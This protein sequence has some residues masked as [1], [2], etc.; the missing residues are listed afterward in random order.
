M[1]RWHLVLAIGLSVRA[2]SAQPV[3]A[4]VGPLQPPER[5]QGP[6][7]SNE[8]AK[9]RHSF[10][11][12]W[13]LRLEV[14]P[15]Y[16]LIYDL[17]IVGGEL[18]VGAEKRFPGWIIFIGGSFT[19]GAR[20]TGLPVYQ[21]HPIVVSFEAVLGPVRLG[22]GARLGEIV[23]PTVTSDSAA[24]DPMIGL[25]AGASVDVARFDKGNRALYVA[26]RVYLD[27]VDSFML[28]GG[29]EAAAI[30]GPSF[31]VGARL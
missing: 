2:A 10:V 14:G 27:C 12:P 7:P 24:E 16:R 22:G 30:W 20:P 8:W 18:T 31:V 3:D 25:F 6:D 11:H 23:L 17:A 28:I 13:A 9:E 1:S 4:P 5:L 19:G 29:N 26:G 15:A 21:F